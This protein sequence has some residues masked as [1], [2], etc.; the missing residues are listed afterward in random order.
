MNDRTASLQ[1]RV[2]YK[3]ASIEL[4][5][6][7]LTHRSCGNENNE[8]LEFLGDSLLNTIIAEAL[9]HQFPQ[10]KEGQLSRLRASLVK[11]DTLAQVAREFDLGEYLQLG[12]GEMKS[13]GHRR[14]SLLA[15]ALEAIIA[16]IYL[17]SDFIT[18]KKCVLAW[19]D[20][21]LKQIN[22]EVTQKDP[23]TQL[24]EFLQ[25]RGQPL[26]EYK[27]INV[28]GAPHEQT[29]TVECF[30]DA[31]GAPVVMDGNSRRNA[32][33]SAAAAALKALAEMS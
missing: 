7:A 31:L 21:R 22:P 10:Q 9:F 29:F 20:Q 24:Q 32:E 23:K 3:F 14:S 5:N 4:L 8:R 13:G 1:T 6:L 2:G 27:V 16:A 26:P 12:E 25:G 18:C 30:V 33:K 19:F 11:G 17:D 15:D 28:N